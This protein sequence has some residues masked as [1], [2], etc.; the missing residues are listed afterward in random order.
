M[1]LILDV[2]RAVRGPDCSNGGPS[3]YLKELTVI[4]CSGP[5]DPNDERPAVM[6]E[7]H[8]PG[9]VRLVLVGEDG[10]AL[11]LAGESGPMFGGNYG[12]TSDSRFNEKIAQLLGH[13]FYGAVPIHD[14]YEGP[15][16]DMGDA[17]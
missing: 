1:G 16:N 4:N 3:G 15:Q 13:R 14:R 6:L 2:Y 12:A 10:K 17:S 8:V 7:S 5:F 9:C 11:K